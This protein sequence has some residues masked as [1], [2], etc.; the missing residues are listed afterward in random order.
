MQ[1]CKST[2][3]DVQESLIVASP[4]SSLLKPLGQNT[5]FDLWVAKAN[6]LNIVQ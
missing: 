5:C 6:I 2:R 3:V 1:Y 4:P